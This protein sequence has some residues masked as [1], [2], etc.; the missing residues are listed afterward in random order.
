MR[1]DNSIARGAKETVAN[2]DVEFGADEVNVA[3]TEIVLSLS[4]GGFRATLFQLGVLK[5]LHEQGLLSRIRH[6]YSVSGGSIMAGFL[7][8]NWKELSNKEKDFEAGCARLISFSKNGVL[9]RIMWKYLFSFL[10]FPLKLPFVN[11]LPLVS[12]FSRSL[13]EI[14]ESEYRKLYGKK[15]LQQLQSEFEA[16]TSGAIFPRFSILSCNLKTAELCSVDQGGFTIW[17]E[18]IVQQ[19]DAVNKEENGEEAH[20]SEE[21][22]LE[23]VPQPLI[24]LVPDPTPIHRFPLAKAVA[25]SSAFPPLFAPVILTKKYLQNP[26][27]KFESIQ[28][29]DGGVYDNLG[30]V[31]PAKNLSSESDS[32]PLLLLVDAETHLQLGVSREF[33]SA[34]ERNLRAN[35]IVMRNLSKRS[36][37]DWKDQFHVVNIRT[38]LGDNNLAPE[39]QRFVG[40]VRT[41]LD[42]F[43]SPVVDALIQHG[44]DTACQWLGSAACPF[45]FVAPASS[46]KN[47]D[48]DQLDYS[49]DWLWRIVKFFLSKWSALTI[50]P[51]LLLV[52][53]ALVA[54]HFWSQ[55]NAAVKVAQ[56]QE[57]IKEIASRRSVLDKIS[58]GCSI[59]VVAGTLDNPEARGSGTLCCV[60]EDS[61]G[62][63]FGVTVGHIESSQDLWNKEP[64]CVVQPGPIDGGTLE[65]RIGQLDSSMLVTKRKGEELD[66]GLFRIDQ[67][68][69][70]SNDVLGWGK[71]IGL[72]DPAVGQ[73]A[74]VMGR[75]TGA[76]ELE[77]AV[78]GEDIQIDFGQTVRNAFVL[79]SPGF[80]IPSSARDLVKPISTDDPDI[81]NII[82]KFQLPIPGDSGGVV[83]NKNGE[84]LGMIVGQSAIGVHV[85]IPLRKPLLDLELNIAEEGGGF[86]QRVVEPKSLDVKASGLKFPSGQPWNSLKEEL[87]DEI[88]AKH[89]LTEEFVFTR[90]Y[91]Q[92]M[93]CKRGVN[94]VDFRC[95]SG[96]FPSDVDFFVSMRNKD[97]KWM[98][99]NSTTFEMWGSNG[100]AIE[101]IV[102]PYSKNDKELP[103]RAELVSSLEVFVNGKKAKWQKSV[104]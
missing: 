83:I 15:S 69:S 60:V 2:E 91:I 96:A 36:Y 61:D 72:A 12:Y 88:I 42:A 4:G 45:K 87:R 97:G 22:D 13:T 17:Q 8:A 84:L 51:V 43:C 38:E 18:E 35:E 75:Q 29:T 93:N 86:R 1:K 57:R 101:L 23:H 73:H 26:K 56:V 37:I 25:A 80:K 24:R 74:I 6:V 31:I 66:I 92:L 77:I 47:V 53:G 52:S 41:D 68:I 100:G 40:A 103:T 55:S 62:V 3:Y 33:S 9:E 99:R 32:K 44:Y 79:Q 46:R 63:R 59:G 78:V 67:G 49:W 90:Y 39:V 82:H 102:S 64:A 28:L 14:L 11:S 98:I 94:S 34:I 20:R 81:K 70:F 71:I 16:E 65:N 89:G 104:E 48:I 21:G 19:D 85:A 58:P 10:F 50:I 30:L 27:A 5:A 76:V 54:N 7:A 95:L